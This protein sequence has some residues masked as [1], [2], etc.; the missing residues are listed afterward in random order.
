VPGTIADLLA[1]VQKDFDTAQAALKAGD[2]TAYAKAYEA[3]RTD[4]AAAV[5]AVNAANASASTTTTTAPGSTTTSS[6]PTTTATTTTPP[7]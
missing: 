3:A 6:A 2:L 5:K 1:K 4:L 7:A